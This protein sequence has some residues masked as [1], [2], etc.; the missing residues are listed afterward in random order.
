MKTEK[1]ADLCL[2]APGVVEET[3][4]GGGQ[5]SEKTAGVFTEAPRPN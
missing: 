1:K 5:A 2:W 3:E 4:D